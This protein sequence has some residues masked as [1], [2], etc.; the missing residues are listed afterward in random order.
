MGTTT[1]TPW[2]KGLALS[3]ASM[4]AVFTGAPVVAQDAGGVTDNSGLIPFDQAF[5]AFEVE[6]P[7]GTLKEV[8]IWDE[9][10]AMLDHPYQYQLDPTVAGNAQGWPSYRLTQP[11]RRSFIH[12]ELSTGQPCWPPT[13]T[14]VEVN[15]PRHLIHPI[16]Y[17]HSTGEEL[18][19]LNIDY[20]GGPGTVADI[21][22]EDPPGSGAYRFT[23]RE[24]EVS[25]GEERIEDDEAAIDF[26]SPI[27]AE[28][29]ATIISTEQFFVPGPGPEGSVLAAEGGAVTGADPGEPGYAGFGVLLAD[30]AEQYSVPAVPG[31]AS[32]QTSVPRPRGSTTRRGATSSRAPDPRRRAG[33]GGLR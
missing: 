21:L 30:T 32:P 23:Y 20:E 5:F 11:R 3:L 22:V 28:T 27:G 14:C 26:N 15:L 17:N 29:E 2:R 25:P 24:V 9:I 31:I 8:P 12:R 19:L 1:L 4:L 6:S 13:A 16:N 7:L 33:F 18:R 10:E